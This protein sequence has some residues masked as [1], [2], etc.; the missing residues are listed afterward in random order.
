MKDAATKLLDLFAGNEAAHGTH[1]EPEW[2]PAKS[3]WAIRST[4]RS[5]RTPATADLWR[6]HLKGTTPLGV[7]PVRADGTV[8]WGTIDLDEYE[9]DVMEVVGRVERDKLP[10]VPCRSKSGGLHLFLFLKEAVPA[11][12]V[13]FSLRNLAARLGI[14]GSEIFPKQTQVLSER[15]D[16]GSWIVM[17]YF[18]GDFGGKLREQVGLK[19][20]G[21]AMTVTEFIAAAEAAKL[22]PQELRDLGNLHANA[23]SKGKRKAN[24]SAAATGPFSDGPPCLQHLSALGI[25]P[26]GQNNTLMMMGIYFKRK[27]PGSWKKQLEDANSKWFVPPHPAEGLTQVIKSLERKEYEYTCK[28]EPMCSHCDSQL[29]VTRKFG[30]GDGGNFPRIS[31][32]SKLNIE[33][34]LWFIDIDDRRLELTTEELQQYGKF[35]RA[36]MDSLNRCYAMMSQGNWLK[37]VNEAM[38]NVTIIEAPRDAG[39]P[40]RF[41]E[42]LEDFLTNRLKGTQKEDLL[43]GRPWEDEETK[44]HFFRLSDLQRF[45]INEGMMRNIERTKIIRRLEVLGGGAYFFNVRGK[46]INVWWVPIDSVQ[47]TPDLPPPPHPESPI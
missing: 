19:K 47:R 7:V 29:C 8:V 46:G 1:G 3:K 9:N 23:G 17:P 13:I 28:V 42:L 31:S 37:V 25:E 24:G 21:S 10:L 36:C 35:H 20:T 40:E 5:L 33:P 26:G 43:L 14:A 2:D 27:D 12:E 39:E 38:Q 4:A 6:A 18:G 44:R 45:L 11:G 15:G 22:T 34:P 41:R 32:I 16:I 30:V